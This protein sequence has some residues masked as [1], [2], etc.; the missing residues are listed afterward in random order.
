MGKKRGRGVRK[1]TGKDAPTDE[2]KK[3]AYLYSQGCNQVAIG[4][5]LGISQPTVSRQLRAAKDGKLLVKHYKLDVSDDEFRDIAD[6]MHRVQELKRMI[7]KLPEDSQNAP[8]GIQVFY[9][10]SSGANP[11]FSGEADEGGYDAEQRAF[12]DWAITFGQNASRFVGSL[13]VNSENVGVGWGR[14]LESLVRAL[15]IWNELAKGSN[16]T[17]PPFF[18]P[19]WGYP[20]VTAAERKNSKHFPWLA[21]ITSSSIAHKLNVW[22]GTSHPSKSLQLVPGRVPEGVP[23]N[24]LDKFS[25]Q[26]LDY[27]PNYRQIFAEDGSLQ[28][29]PDTMLLS[30]GANDAWFLKVLFGTDDAKLGCLAP[31][32]I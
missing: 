16:S 10:G 4:N 8:R 1:D 24:D 14:T 29:V 28:K 19:M 3:V 11:S 12:D 25:S 22:S 2:D 18:L 20:T 9:S 17:E 6:R 5:L 15:P 23:A 32:G 27:L 30:I 31:D 7:D 13:L 21:D 26:Y